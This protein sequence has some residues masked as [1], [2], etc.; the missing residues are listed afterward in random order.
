MAAIDTSHLSSIVE[1]NSRLID[2]A[3]GLWDLTSQISDPKASSQLQEQVK[4]L[5]DISERISSAL[6]NAR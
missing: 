4:R 3:K 6:A 2:T 5:L 1:E